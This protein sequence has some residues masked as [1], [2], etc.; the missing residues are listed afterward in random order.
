MSKIR[1]STK[2]KDRKKKGQGDENDGKD[3]A[4]AY[5]ILSADQCRELLAL[6]IDNMQIKLC[7]IFTLNNNLTDLKEASILDYYTG[8]VW[9]AK[10]RSFTNQ[11]LSGFFTIVHNLLENIKDKHMTMVENLKEF[12]K[13]MVGI[14]VEQSVVPSGGLEFFD[15]NQAKMITEY[16]SSSLFQHYKLYEFMFSHTQAEEIIGTDVDI[17]VAM[18]AD[19]PF[20]PPLDEGI[21]T[22]MYEQFIATPPPSPTPEPKDEEVIEVDISSVLPEDVNIYSGLTPDDV[23]AVIES[24]AKDM[25]GGLKSDVY[26]KLQEKENQI[27]A[28]INKIHRVAET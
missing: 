12:Q 5:K 27:I 21:T 18:S 2:S 17:E 23:K 1:R 3:S 28:K 14:G 13:M 19:V 4:L 9:W 20:P 11:Q 10:E 6:G 15:I 16:V 22:S 25:L 24:V 26:K 7:D 8:A